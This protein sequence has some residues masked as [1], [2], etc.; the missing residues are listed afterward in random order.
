MYVMLCNA[1]YRFMC[2][3]SPNRRFK[4]FTVQF[5]P[6]VLPKNLYHFRGLHTTILVIDPPLFFFFLINF[7]NILYYCSISCS[8]KNYAFFYCFTP[9]FCDILSP[10]KRQKVV[11]P[12]WVM[13]MLSSRFPGL[14]LLQ[15]AINGGFRNTGDTPS[16]LDGLCHG[17]SR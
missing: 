3:D 1:M 7:Y 5:S 16:S 17:K 2:S 8:D 4:K 10:P 6:G 12:G 9:I 13:V 15:L 11:F 14:Q